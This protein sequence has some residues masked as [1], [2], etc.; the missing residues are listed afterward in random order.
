M[1]QRAAPARQVAG[2]IG[3]VRLHL[4]PPSL[5]TPCP[6]CQFVVRLIETIETVG[7]GMLVSGARRRVFHSF[8]T[9]YR[10]P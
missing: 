1:A 9:S 4:L 7:K 3:S 8:H 2:Y 5:E 6:A 10:N